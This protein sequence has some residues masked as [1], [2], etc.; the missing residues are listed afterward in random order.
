MN[1]VRLKTARILIVDDNVGNV[2]L[3]S[4]MLERIGYANIR[5]TTDSREVVALTQEF[6]PDLIVL[7]LMM[8]HLDGFQVM[9]QLET[10]I[11]PETYL[12]ILVVTADVAPTTK[13]K[14]LAAGATDFLHKPFDA[15]EIFM[16]IRNLLQTRFLHLAGENQKQLLEEKVAERTADL[17]AAL[18]ELKEAQHTML[19]QERLRA[20]GEM[21]GGIVHDFNNALMS[22]VGYSDLL[23]QDPDSL[24][25]KAVVTDYLKT[26]N[27][28]GRDAAHVV[29]RLREFYR[30][31]EIIDVFDSIAL[32]DLIEQGVLLTQPKWRD[33]ALADGRTIEINLELEK[34]PPIAGNAAEL[35]ETLTNLIFNATD[36]MPR[37]GTITLRT[38][39]TDDK[40]V[41]EVIDTGTGMNEEVRLRCLE[42]FFS[43]KGD[44]GTGLGLAMVF[45]I[46]KRH[47]GE[48]AIESA[49]DRGTTFRITFPSQIRTFES[50]AGEERPALRRLR[51]LVVDDE[52]IARDVVTKYL[53]ADGHDVLA[54]NRPAEALRQFKT[55]AFDLVITDQAMPAMSGVQLARLIK[56]MNPA[57]RVILLTGFSDPALADGEKPAGIDALLHKPMSQSE[58]RRTIAE[59]I[60][61]SSTALEVAA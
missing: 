25:D 61:S 24:N 37:G 29:G 43:T 13:R 26:M 16:R 3:L 2:A 28:A 30:P 12:P 7:D 57:Q 51:I 56:E 60:P 39:R 48:L 27:T 14:A 22:V 20:F 1:E 45:G 35:R 54:L 38:R 55:D 23:L 5:S 19:Q 8:P 33:Q 42:P 40:V 47:E 17:S 34:I 18:Q 59:L 36:A 4:N 31:K 32:N 46:I 9:Q 53:Q 6:Q 41:L 50:E 21:A 44:I 52:P 49:P 10:V 11:S 15:S 58:L